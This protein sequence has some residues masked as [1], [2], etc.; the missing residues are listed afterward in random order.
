MKAIILLLSV[1]RFEKPR[2]LK[3]IVSLATVPDNV[4]NQHRSSTLSIQSF[5]TLYIELLMES[6]DI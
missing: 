2:V 3:K 4:D 1:Q 6:D 5:G